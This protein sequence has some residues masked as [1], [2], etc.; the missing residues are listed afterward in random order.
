MADVSYELE[1]FLQIF[2]YYVVMFVLMDDGHQTQLHRVWIIS[3]AT[4][5]RQKF[6]EVKVYELHC[7]APKLVLMHF[8]ILCVFYELVF[9]E[10]TEMSEYAFFVYEFELL[11]VQLILYLWQACLRRE[12]GIEG[13]GE[14]RSRVFIHRLLLIW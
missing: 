6:F 10:T 9:V 4:Y 5:A 13:T 1:F 3:E 11:A 14:K 7:F 8:F 12:A 2:E